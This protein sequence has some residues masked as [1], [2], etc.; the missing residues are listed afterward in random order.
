MR[1]RFGNNASFWAKEC[2][3]ELLLPLLPKPASIT[4]NELYEY[5]MQV[6]TVLGLESKKKKGKKKKGK[7]K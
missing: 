1:D 2:G 4:V 5:K 7:K 3:H 6:K